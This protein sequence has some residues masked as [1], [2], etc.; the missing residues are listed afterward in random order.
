MRCASH[1]LRKTVSGL[2]AATALALGVTLVAAPS[3]SAAVGSSACTKNIKDATY[4]VNNYAG[5]PMQSGPGYKDKDV[6]FLELGTDVRVYCETYKNGYNWYYGKAGKKKGWVV[7]RD[8][9]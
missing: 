2:T 1:R 3:A 4:M 9:H 8:F 6:K 7:S 5:T